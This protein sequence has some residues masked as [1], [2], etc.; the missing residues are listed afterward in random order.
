M[1][2]QRKPRPSD[3]LTASDVAEIYG[4]HIRTAENIVRKVARANGGP[5]EDVIDGVPIRRL[6][7]RREWVEPCIGQRAS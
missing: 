4:F 7:V 5:V 3:L 6:F 1:N 2:A